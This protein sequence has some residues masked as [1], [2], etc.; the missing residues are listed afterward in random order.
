VVHVAY[1]E[2]TFPNFFSCHMARMDT[3]DEWYYEVSSRKCDMAALAY[4][5]RNGS[6]TRMYGFNS[7]GFDYPILHLALWAFDAGYRG[8]AL[9]LILYNKGQEIIAAQNRWEHQ[10][11]PWEVK[12][13]QVDLLTL[14]HF[15]NPAKMTSLKAIEFNIESPSIEETPIP[16]GTILTP[17]QMDE[18]LGYGTND[19]RET[20][21]FAHLSMDAVRFRE[22]L[23][24]RGWFGEEC[25]SWNDGKIGLEHF[26]QKLE[27]RAPGITK[28]EPIYRPRIYLSECILPYIQYHRPELQQMLEKLKTI[29]F[30]GH[31]T[32]GAYKENVYVDGFKFVIGQGGIHGSVDRRTFMADRGYI[33]ADI[34]VEGYYPSTSIANGFHPEHLGSIFD[35]VYLDLKTTRNI[36]KAAGDKVEAGTLKLSSNKVFGDM[37]SKYSFV[38]DPQ[39]MIKITINGQLLQ[40]ML[41]EQMMRIP[42]L[43]VIQ[44][45]TDGMT[46]RVHGSR[47][48]DLEGMCSWWESVTRMRLEKKEYAAFWV[49]DVNNY[50]GLEAPASQPVRPGWEKH[51]GKRKR[52]GEYDWE[53]L[54][55]STGGQLAWNRDFSGR[56]IAKAAEAAL[57]DDVDPRSF[58]EGH[59]RPYDF[60]MRARVTGGHTLQLGDGT[61]LQKTVRYYLCKTG[62][63]LVKIMPPLKGMPE[64]RRAGIH[65][66]GQA[67]CLG[68]LKDGY[69]CSWCGERF[70]TKELF[71]HH[72]RSV[73]QWCVRVVNRWVPEDGLPDLNHDFYV[74]GAEA[75]LF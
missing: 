20:K 42:T 30:P 40:V 28:R 35:D 31:E 26:K 2:E 33:I 23:I 55:G 29:S 58:I 49:R 66:E 11:K 71:G 36:A 46:V 75:L 37:G 59:D 53:M 63:P 38:R 39:C 52:K 7:L 73:H 18:V 14:H 41:V 50:I 72:N 8:E 17:S 61:P 21:R 65:A 74:Q 13:P 47:V 56:V 48:T 9:A 45:N 68:T 57:V 70:R 1:D 60:M 5:M 16:F 34:D 22:D 69:H 10:V 62:V 67:T 54:S 12:I 6:I 51:S 64:P 32:K 25:L 19:T 27:A 3:D 4:D 43:E 24:R 44:M 15:D